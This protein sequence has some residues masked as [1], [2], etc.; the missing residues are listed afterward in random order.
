M[1]NKALQIIISGHSY[2]KKGAI[3]KNMQSYQIYIYNYEKRCEFVRRGRRKRKYDNA[4]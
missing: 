3:T 4:H 1:Q 2:L